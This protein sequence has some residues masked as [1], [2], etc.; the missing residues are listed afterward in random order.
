MALYKGKG[1][2]VF[3]I[4][5]PP[6]GSTRRENFDAQ[7]EAGDLVPVEETAKPKPAAKPKPDTEAPKE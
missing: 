3:E 6:E 4:E 1:G 7:L 2:A 5:P